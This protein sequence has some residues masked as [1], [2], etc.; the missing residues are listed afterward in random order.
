MKKPLYFG[1]KDLSNIKGS[2]SIESLINQLIGEKIKGHRQKIEDKNAEVINTL[3]DISRQTKSL[4]QKPDVEAKKASL[5]HNLKVFK[6]YEIDKKLNRQIEFDK[7]SNRFKNL[8]E[9]EEEIIANL[10]EL[11]SNFGD[12]FQSYAG[13]K[14][15]EN[16]D[17]V[18]GAYTS[19][20]NFFKVFGQ[21][22]VLLAQ[23]KNENANLVAFETRFLKRYEDLKD[24]FSKIKRQINLPN[25]QADDYVKFTKELENS[26]FKLKELEKVKNK[27][28]LLHKQLIVSLTQL[29]K[30]WNDE[31]NLVNEEIQKINVDQ[32]SIKIVMKFKGD[33]E[34]FREY[35]KDSVRGTGVRETNIHALAEDYSD[36]IEIYRDLSETTTA[37]KV[38]NILSGAQF[39]SFKTRFEENLTSFLTY[40][41][42]LF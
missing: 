39:I 24:E 12:N 10:G 20:D 32:T 25:I 36:M 26:D 7:D 21:L 41:T 33:K 27:S 15:K 34:K 9:F 3:N 38:S 6:D 42:R 4:S 19:F 13:Y 11:I 14:S 18:D 16:A 8:K 31:F 29:Q 37:T 1:Q 2:T 30:L 23:M 17:L 40:R 28:A 22:S 35:L 5:E